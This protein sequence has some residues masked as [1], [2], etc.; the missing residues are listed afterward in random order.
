MDI[1]QEVDKSEKELILEQRG[2]LKQ[3]SMTAQMIK[4]LVGSKGWEMVRAYLDERYVSL[5]EQGADTLQELAA[6]NARMDE[7][8][9][10]LKYV[11]LEFDT[12]ALHL[13]ALQEEVEFDDEYVPS[14]YEFN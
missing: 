10:L 11:K 6:R 5:A 7:I 8:K 1:Y 2:K 3:S 9:Q 4:D 13:R 14:P 12:A